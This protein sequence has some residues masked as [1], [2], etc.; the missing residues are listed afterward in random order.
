MDRCKLYHPL[1]ERNLQNYQMQHLARKYDFGK[2]SMV[3]KLMVEHIN[4]AMDKAEAALG[5]LQG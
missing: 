3:S 5:I 2:E 1:T 4:K